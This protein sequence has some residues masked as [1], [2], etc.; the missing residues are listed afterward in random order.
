MRERIERSLPFILVVV[1][2]LISN[3]LLSDTKK[4]P[5]CTSAGIIAIGSKRTERP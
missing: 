5:F 1:V 2:L 4:N 3:A